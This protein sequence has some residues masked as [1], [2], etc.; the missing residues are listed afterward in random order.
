LSA[1]EQEQSVLRLF[2]DGKN[3]TD[4]A[5]ELGISL[6][7][8]RNHLHHVNDKLGTH[9]RLQRRYARDASQAYLNDLRMDGFDVFRNL[10]RCRVPRYFCVRGGTKKET[11]HADADG[12]WELEDVQGPQ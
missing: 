9:D 10:L 1:P 8:L 11:N 5:K 7:T 12:W 2:S 4:I 6:Q 3:P